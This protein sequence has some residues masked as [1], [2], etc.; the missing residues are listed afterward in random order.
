MDD[1]LKRRFQ[2]LVEGI[3]DGVSDE[4]AVLRSGR[5]M[6][7]RQRGLIAVASAASIAVAGIGVNLLT[8]STREAEPSVIDTSDHA[9]GRFVPAKEGEPTYLLSEFEIYYPY[10]AVDHMQRMSKHNAQ[11]RK[12][13]CAL[14]GRSSQCEKRWDE[15]GF[16]YAWRWSTDQFPGDVDCQVQ[17]YTRNG[18]IAGETVFGLS[19][20]ESTSRPNFRHVVPVPV[21]ERPTRATAECEAGVY[22]EGPGFDVTFVRA[23]P[24]TPTYVGGEESP[25]ER[26]RLIFEVD[27][28][29]EHGAD[30]RMCRLKLW[31]Q[32]GK[33]LEGDSFTM[34]ARPGPLE[35]ETGYPATD[36]IVDAEMMCDTLRGS[37]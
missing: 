16:T 1:E 31:F 20:L 32:S 2:H 27:D 22:E 10:V 23:E 5:K 11:R 36:P 34:A 37:T 21:T 33:V 12:E 6:R 15:A 25:E 9:P 19:G 35:F 13:Y 28:V 8:T 26:I 29:T 7:W 24:Y 4:V 3:P 30:T 14:P 17:L 18:E